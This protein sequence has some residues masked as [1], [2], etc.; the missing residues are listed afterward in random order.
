MKGLIVRINSINC[1]NN[2]TTFGYI[3]PHKT[4][5]KFSEDT[6]EFLH[7]TAQSIKADKGIDAYNDY[8]NALD[9]LRRKTF[10]CM[11]IVNKYIQK[12]K[13]AGKY[14]EFLGEFELMNMP[15]KYREEKVTKEIIKEPS[16]I[17]RLFGKKPKKVQETTLEH[18]YD[19]IYKINPDLFIYEYNAP[20]DAPELAQYDHSALAVKL[21]M[22]EAEIE[23]GNRFDKYLSSAEGLRTLA[24]KTDEALSKFFNQK[25]EY[26]TH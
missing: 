5:G 10:D 18:H 7:R 17:G 15:K 14:S 8:F 19:Y 25:F 13:Q 24:K 21:G 16:I 9:E 6:A 2:N 4:G 1:N 20:M 22:Y 3:L 23:D 26:M 12:I 11:P